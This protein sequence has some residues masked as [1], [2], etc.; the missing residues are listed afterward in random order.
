MWANLDHGTDPN[1]TVVAMMY[2]PKN[3][4]AAG[5][6]PRLQE[7]PDQA[8]RH[9]GQ[10]RENEEIRAHDAER[11]IALGGDIGP[12]EEPEPVSAE[13]NHQAADPPK[14]RQD[15]GR[16]GRGRRVGEHHDGGGDD[17]HHEP[18]HG[19]QVG[20]AAARVAEFPGC[21][22]VDK[23]GLDG[24]RHQFAA[25]DLLRP[26]AFRFPPVIEK[27]P[28]APLVHDVEQRPGRNQ[29]DHDDDIGLHDGRRYGK[30]G[31]RI[32]GEHFLSPPRLGGDSKCRVTSPG[33]DL[34]YAPIE[35]MNARAARRRER[36]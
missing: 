2:R 30:P 8:Q 3:T 20:D 13:A 1:S 11:R 12:N 9:A 10:E 33:L 32:A 5:T 27:I 6:A 15:G 17:I 34:R 7:R 29:G 14:L 24:E 18:V 26:L 28:G 31:K 22:N 35:A 4:S 16:R 19:Q 36:R 21:Q 25:T 23:A